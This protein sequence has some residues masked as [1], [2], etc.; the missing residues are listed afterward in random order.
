MSCPHTDDSVVEYGETS[1]D[2][3]QRG[4]PVTK[5]IDGGNEHR[6]MYIHRVLVTNLIPGRKYIYHVGK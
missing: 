3:T 1:L 6:T 2:Q 5:F 4:E